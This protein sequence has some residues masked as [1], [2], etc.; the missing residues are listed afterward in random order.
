VRPLPAQ[1]IGAGHGLLR[2]LDQRG[3]LRPEE[4]V[5][6][7]TE[8]ELFPPDVEADTGRTR[9]H[10]SL[11][12]A[13]GLVRE[14]AGAIELSD[15]GRRYVRAGDPADVFAVAPGQAEWLR[16]VLRERHV[17]DSIWHGAAIGLSLFATLGPGERVDD[18]DFGRAAAYLGRTGWDNEQTFALQGARFIRLLQDLELL[19]PDRR[20]TPT[21]AQL[22]A[23]LGLPLHARLVDLVLQLNPEAVVRDAPPPPPEPAPPPPPP[24]APPPPAAEYASVV[25][26]A[27]PPPPPAPAPAPAP[28]PAEI[29]VLR[30]TQAVAAIAPPAPP[31][32]P[33][34][35]PGTPAPAQ[36]AFLGLDAVAAAAAR[37]GLQLDPG[38]LAAAT[39][40]LASGRHLVLTGGPGQGK[41]QLAL[42]L[43]EAATAAGR[44]GGVL[45]AAAGAGLNGRDTLGRRTCDGGFEPGLVTQAIGTDRWLVLDELDRA[46]LDRALGRVSPVLGGQAVALPGGGELQPQAA[47]RLIATMS[48]LS[49]V[50]AA[51][52]ALRRRFVFVEVPVLGRAALEALVRRW[53]G[54]DHVAAAV[55]RR[56]VAASDVAELGPGLY[57]DAVA[58]VRARRALAPA[59]ERA[60]LLEALAG[61]VLPQLEGLGEDVA[62]QVFEAATAA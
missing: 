8:A 19:G 2:A 9:Q 14:N 39:A 6:E 17:T 4:F 32:S 22:H 55:G 30:P 16:R 43:A 25:A 23:E 31:P 49:G 13:A 40:A 42:A 15:L 37:R 48:D 61:F 54:D 21:G 5:T 7:F 24:M 35:P 58:Y 36:P 45:V 53:A 50:G 18:P 59:D 51:S 20:L 60:L 56:L 1:R 62:R 41:T 44:C 46:K 28:P 27:A 34:P 57:E 33:P 47:W 11:L 38:V 12:R 10:L 52:A 29:P 3:R 26:P